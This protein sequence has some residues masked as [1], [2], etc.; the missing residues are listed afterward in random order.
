MA[1]VQSTKCALRVCKIEGAD[2]RAHTQSIFVYET[3]CKP[4]LT[5]T[6]TINDN[7]NIIN[8]LQ[9]RG[10]E[11]VSFVIDTGVALS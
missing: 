6:I 2:V 7:A 11:R 10:G 4:Y 8:N 3:M 5:A 1:I 9:L